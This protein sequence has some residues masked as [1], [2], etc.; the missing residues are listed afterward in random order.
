[1]RDRRKNGCDV[2]GVDSNAYNSHHQKRNE[3]TVSR[4]VEKKS[5]KQGSF[6]IISITPM[7]NPRAVSFQKMKGI[8]A[9]VSQDDVIER[10]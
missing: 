1:M 6:K 9:Q 2:K 5:D 8:C 10:E 4:K 7:Y 3:K